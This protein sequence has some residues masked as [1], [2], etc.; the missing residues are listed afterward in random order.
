MSFQLE[1]ATISSAHSLFHWSSSFSENGLFMVVETTGREVRKAEDIGI[2]LLEKLLGLYSAREEKNLK[3]VRKLL[4]A[5][6]DNQDI[7]T[8]TVGIIINNICY[9]GNRG[10]GEVLISRDGKVGQILSSNDVLSGRLKNQ[11]T[12]LFSTKTFTNLVDYDSRASLIAQK[13]IYKVN[14]L[15][16]NIFD[17]SA[18]EREGA[19]AMYVLIN[20]FQVSDKA[21]LGKPEDIKEQLKL[22]LRLRN[23][24]AYLGNLITGRGDGLESE[25]EKKSKKTLFTIAVILT[26]LLIISI[27][28]NINNK[29][30]NSRLGHLKEVLGLVSHQYDEAISLT[31]LNPLR[32][33]SLLSDSK[34]SLGEVLKEFPKNSKEYKEITDWLGKVSEEEVAAYKIY[35]LTTVPEFFD[36]SLIK[37]DGEGTKIVSYD[38]KKGI[39]DIKNRVVYALS[40]DSKKADILA[41]ADTV[42][43]AQTIAIHGSNIYILSTDGITALDTTGKASVMVIKK[44][45]KWGEIVSMASFGG[46]LYLLD[47]KNNTIWKYMSSDAGFS[48]RQS[49]L[50]AGIRVDFSQA[51]KL[52]IDG[53]VWVLVSPSEVIKLENGT[54]VPYPLKGFSE[55]LHDIVSVS[56][57]ENDKFLYILDRSSKRIVV[58]DKDGTYQSQYQ[59]DGLKNAN[60][61]AAS[62]AEKKIFVL[63]GSKIYA[64][65][66]R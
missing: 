27:F 55:E 32:A 37:K 34:M 66:I 4:A 31:D 7:V 30:N 25:E 48:G 45:E 29:N 43:D 46:N 42:K 13:D 1:T 14:E 26:I 60:D 50:N 2:E 53:S 20:S 3:T 15:G 47:R 9:L 40:T 64:I 22:K 28:L 63:T 12:L 33:R 6:K 49:Y 54:V 61:I 65:D 57:D 11:D 21:D 35:K 10:Y 23:W 39:L 44:D 38:E 16:A 52:Q 24:S 18:K 17:G 59:W 5:A 41:G 58:F 56:T 36:L 8:L 51:S 62:E 19:L